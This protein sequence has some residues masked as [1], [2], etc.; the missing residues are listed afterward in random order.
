M[1][2]VVRTWLIL[3]KKNLDIFSIIYEFLGPYS[4]TFNKNK[5]IVTPAKE[6]NKLACFFW[7]RWQTTETPGSKLK[8]EQTSL[9]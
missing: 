5:I 6:V 4:K 7:P 9:H 2:L 1:E 3:A 8:R